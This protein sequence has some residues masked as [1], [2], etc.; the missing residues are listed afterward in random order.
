MSA[1]HGNE[2]LGLNNIFFF[3][4]YWPLAIK[5]TWGGCPRKRLG[6]AAFKAAHGFVWRR[7]RFVLV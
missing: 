7:R 2:Y 5:P 1:K 6:T 3:L 4:F